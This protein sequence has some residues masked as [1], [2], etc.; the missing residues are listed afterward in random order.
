M[1]PTLSLAAA[2]ILTLTG[3]GAL[4]GDEPAPLTPDYTPVS[5]SPAPPNARLYADCIAQAAEARTYDRVHDDGTE[6]IR[7]TCTGAPA[8]AFYDG[9]AAWSAEHATE[10][11]VAGRTYRATNPVRQNLFGADFCWTDGAGGYGCEMAFNAGDFLA[12]GE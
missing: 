10:H 8:R 3:C 6:V 2:A 1:K 11:A 7:F 9:L 12:Y 5:G 4:G